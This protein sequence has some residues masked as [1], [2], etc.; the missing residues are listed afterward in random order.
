MQVLWD[1]SPRTAAEVAELLADE[2]QWSPRTVKTLLARLV[3]KGALGYEEQGRRYLY[4]PRISRE[5]CI[6][7]EGR[8]LADRA[9]AGATSPLLMHFVERSQLSQDEIDELKALLERKEPRR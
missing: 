3:K 8:S 4:W 2:T 5:S 1:R 7:A 6:D 9:F